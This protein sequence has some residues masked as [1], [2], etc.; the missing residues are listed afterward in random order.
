MHSI[1]FVKMSGSG[2]DFIII[3]NRQ[4]AWDRLVDPAFVQAVCRRKL[5]VGADGLIKALLAGADQA[6]PIHFIEALLEGKDG[7]L[8]IPDHA[9]L[10][11][12]TFECWFKPEAGGP[13]EQTLAFFFAMGSLSV[14]ETPS[15][16]SRP[17]GPGSE[18][19]ASPCWPT[20]PRSG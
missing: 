17:P 9:F 10:G 3:D 20:P 5:S 11:S 15:R 19:P 14:R 16:F 6:G 8:R 4:G 12:R 1:P 7:V 18:A 2:N 13:A